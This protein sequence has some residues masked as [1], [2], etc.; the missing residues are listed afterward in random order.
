MK[1]ILQ[2]SI[3]LFVAFFGL[4]FVRNAASAKEFDT[5]ETFTIT[6]IGGYATC[7]GEV[8]TEARYGDYIRIFPDIKA[9]EYVRGWKKDFDIAGKYGWYCRFEAEGLMIVDF[10]MPYRNVV[11]T[12]ITERQKPYTIDL[13]DGFENLVHNEDWYNYEGNLIKKWFC[14]SAGL[15]DYYSDEFDLDNNGTNDLNFVCT[16]GHVYPTNYM[17]VPSYGCTIHGDYLIDKP[18]GGP[19]WPIT[20]KFGE[21]TIQ[22]EYTVTVN[23]GYGYVDK[24]N[25]KKTSFTAAPGSY[26]ELLADWQEGSYVSGW[27][28]GGIE[29]KCEYYSWNYEYNCVSSHFYMPA[30]DIEVTVIRDKQTPYIIDFTKGY[31]AV[32][33]EIEYAYPIEDINGDK[34][35]DF[36]PVYNPD[37]WIPISDLN[38]TE[39]TIQKKP[40]NC[41]YYPVTLKVGDLKEYYSIQ[42][43]GGHA[44][45]ENGKVITQAQ[46]G[47]RVCVFRDK[48]PGKYWKAW[49][50][51]YPVD[52]RMVC[53]DFIMPAT[54]VTFTAETT[55]SQITYT[56]DLTDSFT[57][58]SGDELYLIGNAI[59]IFSGGK[60]SS[61]APGDY[62]D[63]D[64]NGT[65]DIFLWNYD[66]MRPNLGK[67]IYRRDYNLGTKYTVAIDD[68]QIGSLTLV[69]NNEKSDKPV[70]DT[71]VGPFTVTLTGKVKFNEESDNRRSKTFYPGEYVII[72][73]KNKRIDLHCEGIDSSNLPYVSRYYDTYTESYISF[74]MP[75]HDVSITDINSMQTPLELDLRSGSC[76]IDLTEDFD[77]HEYFSKIT[78]AVWYWDSIGDEVYIYDIDH[79]G[80]YDLSYNPQNKK[81]VV[82]A[83]PY[84]Q[85]FTKLEFTTTNFSLKYS[86]LT[87]LLTDKNFYDIN[88]KLY[89]TDNLD[90][91]VS[92]SP[93]PI[94]E[95]EEHVKNVL[96][97][98]PGTVLTVNFYKTK[99][100]YELEEYYYWTTDGRFYFTPDEIPGF[101]LDQ[102]EETDELISIHGFV[103]P[104]EEVNF[105]GIYKMNP[106]P[107]A[108]PMPTR[109]VTPTPTP[110]AAPT[111]NVTP[112]LVP[113]EA[114]G[115]TDKP[116]TD[117]DSEG[118]H[119]FALLI[120][121]LVLCMVGV[122]FYAV[123]YLRRMKDKSDTPE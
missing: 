85:S 49:K 82:L 45:D 102:I 72:S 11:I 111:A 39:L 99:G 40:N 8:V 38:T 5:E 68:G 10:D 121:G 73:G 23:G 89:T 32:P 30:N 75:Y 113:S 97:A 56:L 58:L 112:T 24:T 19:F 86:P 81:L 50:S 74:Y 16:G 14:Q 52:C 44:E 80:E 2:K 53:F 18:N 42:I 54:D 26:V 92:K 47:Q 104:E 64:K 29:Q 116:K 63:F 76:V 43:I 88:Y 20:V 36:L 123:L 78:E 106:K 4:C 90:V 87:V 96:A 22:K 109:T 61:S 62:A 117:S 59:R 35:K 3:V 118:V 28:F 55:T 108:T 115:N 48:E 122:G 51:T 105:V 83:S 67:G 95:T 94:I 46:S 60:S 98:T 70:K 57:F 34:N 9:G 110:T 91:F 31:A 27:D 65:D 107:T 100:S 79:D 13:T 37:F 6:V 41:Q 69:V 120:A 71:S 21:R 103:M 66:D 17:L 101:S 33:Q 1:R 77:F 15:K 119:P 12:A 84:M 25:G 7:D 93:Y 114:P